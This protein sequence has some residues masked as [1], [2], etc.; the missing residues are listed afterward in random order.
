MLKPLSC[1]VLLALAACSSKP[2]KG[3]CV[4]DFDALG[5]KGTAC[6]VVD[7]TECVDDM[8]PSVVDLATSKKK[9]FTP[10]K[11]CADVGYA[12]AGCSNVPIA[13]SFQRTCPL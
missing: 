3:A 5:D 10:N 4:V 12:K 7:E 11:T 2:T 13:W 6:T 1:V 9:A 8:S